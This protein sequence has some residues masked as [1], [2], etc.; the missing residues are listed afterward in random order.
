VEPPIYLDHHATTP[1][2]PRVV[3]AMLPFFSEQFG[4][5]ASLTH[6]HGRRAANAVE[7]A[8]IAVA[9]FFKVQPNEIVFT[10]KPISM[11]SF[12]FSLLLSFVTSITAV[13]PAGITAPL[14]PVT[15]SFNVAEKRSPTLFVFVQTLELD[16]SVSVVPDAIAPT[17]PPELFSPDVTVFPDGVR[18]G[19]VDSGFAA[20]AVGFGAGRDVRGFDVAR[21]GVREGSAA[22]AAGT[23][24]SCGCAALSP[25]ASW[26][27]RL[28]AVS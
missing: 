21:S 17:L 14:D 20:G 3:E 27:S 4:N 18:A 22:G 25:V 16:A 10:A 5:P 28:S 19:A 26:R 7:D 15:A 1:C 2:D 6:E 11:L 23:S 12:A 9:R 24:F 13:A 8:R